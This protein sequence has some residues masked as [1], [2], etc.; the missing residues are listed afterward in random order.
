MLHFFLKL[1]VTAKFLS[2]INKQEV[3][4]QS[5]RL[6]DLAGKSKGLLIKILLGQ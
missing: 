5:Q 2:V 1:P 3:A 4:A 6:P